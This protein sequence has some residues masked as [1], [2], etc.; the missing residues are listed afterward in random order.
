MYINTLE[1]L[2]FHLN[3]DRQF[4]SGQHLYLL[5]DS[6]LHN[7]L[8]STYF[9][10]DGTLEYYPIFL[11][12]HLE[13]HIHCSPYLVK[14]SADSQK[15]IEWFFTYGKQW[16]FFYL[17]E[18]SLDEALKHWQSII[19]PQT[20]DT[21]NNIENHILL[22]F[23]DPKILRSILCDEDQK[24]ATHAL[25]PCQFLYFQNENNQWIKHTPKEDS[26]NVTQQ[27]QGYSLYIKAISKR[28][29]LMLWDKSPH[30]ME[31]FS[32]LNLDTAIEQGVS[33]AL[34]SNF[35]QQDSILAFLSL[36]LERG[37]KILGSQEIQRYLQ[38]PSIPYA[39][40][41]YHLR[42]KTP[43]EDTWNQTPKPPIII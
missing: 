20:N 2:C 42:E 22:R 13:E 30:L 1:E 24:K 17:S 8:S 35:T 23:Y 38:T 16:G 34:N 37:P 3:N 39:E 5:F 10:L 9:Q 7:E 27:D 36:W 19:F 14:I 26:A 18:H 11:N 32:S 12:T 41:I 33:I 31:K 25:A 43:Q 40:K 21:K 29:E 15:F 6:N 4:L 28:S